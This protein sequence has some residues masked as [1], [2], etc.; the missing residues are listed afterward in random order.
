MSLCVKNELSDLTK[1]QEGHDQLKNEVKSDHQRKA[2]REGCCER[3]EAQM[4]VI[5]REDEHQE[6]T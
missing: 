5:N 6:E 1:G 3:G 2:L 4:G